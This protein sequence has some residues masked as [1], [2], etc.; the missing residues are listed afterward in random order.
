MM[1]S[2]TD[3]YL[4]V[5]CLQSSAANHCQSMM[6]NTLAGVIMVI[7]FFEPLNNRG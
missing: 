4:L 7:L 3:V 6:T 1:Q 5:Y 2:L